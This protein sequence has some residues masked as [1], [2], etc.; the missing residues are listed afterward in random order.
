MFGGNSTLLSL[1]NFRISPGS[2]LQISGYKLRKHENDYIKE[3]GQGR[4]HAKIVNRND[5][6]V[7]LHYDVYIDGK[8]VTFHM[9]MFLRAER[10]RILKILRNEGLQYREYKEGEFI[11]LI[12]KY[13]V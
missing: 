9:P 12:E 2:A 4:F 13:N 7:E 3:D 5:K 1:K 10:K 11:K 8:H 6:A